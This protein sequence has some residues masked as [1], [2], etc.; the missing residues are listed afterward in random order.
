MLFKWVYSRKAQ[1][2]GRTELGLLPKTR[3]NR[4]IKK[5]CCWDHKHFTSLHWALPEHRTPS[6]LSHIWMFSLGFSFSM[7]CPF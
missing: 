5:K 2:K 7:K 1:V 3:R 4:A 6:S